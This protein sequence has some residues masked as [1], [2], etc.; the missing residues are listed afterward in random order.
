MIM[1]RQEGYVYLGKEF[2]GR[3][4]KRAAVLFACL[5]VVPAVLVVLM[6]IAPGFWEVFLILALAAIAADGIFVLAHGLRYASRFC[7]AVM[8]ATLR[9]RRG[10]CCRKLCIVRYADV[11]RVRVKRYFRKKNVDSGVQE[12]SGAGKSAL[13]FLSESDAVY[14]VRLYCGS[15]KYDLKYLSQASAA[16]V[17]SYFEDGND[18]R[19]F[20]RGE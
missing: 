12:Y 19:I 11:N 16:A 10:L 15:G 8:P 5:L 2:A 20:A 9:I 3:V 17:L 13:R 1:K 4:K 7:F 14:D 6:F 18:E